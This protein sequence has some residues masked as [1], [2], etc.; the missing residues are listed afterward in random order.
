MKFENKWISKVIQFVEKFKVRKVSE[1]KTLTTLSKT[2]KVEYTSTIASGYVLDT[3]ILRYLDEY[4][5]LCLVL[6][7]MSELPYYVTAIN[8]KELENKERLCNA[9]FIKINFDDV[10]NKIEKISG[11][12]INYKEITDEVEHTSRMFQIALS[13]YRRDGKK[14]LHSG[15]SEILA[16]AVK[17]KSKLITSDKGLIECCKKV[18]CEYIDFHNKVRNCKQVFQVPYEFRTRGKN[19]SYRGVSLS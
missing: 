9:K 11:K 13:N 7:D 5:D 3:C 14:L 12:K 19:I 15:D 2:N 10:I 6:K 18:N 16:F 17:T 4:P 8:K 1:A